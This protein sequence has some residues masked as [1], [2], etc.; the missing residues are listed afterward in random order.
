MFDKLDTIWHSI[1]FHNTQS[2][3]N[4]NR[5]NGN[6]SHLGKNEKGQVWS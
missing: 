2:V 3:S 1:S 5:R 4:I 6:V